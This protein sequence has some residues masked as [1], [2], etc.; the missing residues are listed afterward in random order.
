M[1]RAEILDT[2]KSMVTGQREQDYGSV[3]NNFAQIARY[4]T[5]YLYA[6]ER[7]RLDG[8]DV[9]IMMCLFK[10]ARL[11]TGRGSPDTWVDLAGYAA[12][13]GEISTGEEEGK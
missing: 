12:C 10:I 8:R 9:A 5:D 3:E 1:L 2:A 7:T 13:G 11:N 4:W 6:H